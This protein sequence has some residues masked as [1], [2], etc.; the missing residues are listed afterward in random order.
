MLCRERLSL[1][2]VLYSASSADAP[3]LRRRA[4]VSWHLSYLHASWQMAKRQ[5]VSP[6]RGLPEIW[7]PRTS[8]W[9]TR[10]CCIPSWTLT[11]EKYGQLADD[12]VHQLVRHGDHLHHLLAL[13]MRLHPQTG[14]CLLGDCFHVFTTWH[15]QAVT[16]LAIDLNHHGD[17]V[18]Y[19][20]GLV[21]LGPGLRVDA[22]RM[23]AAV[24]QLFGDVGRDGG[25]DQQHLLDRPR[26]DIATLQRGSQ[27]D[28]QIRQLHQRA[29]GSVVLIAVQ[30]IAHAFDRLMHGAAQ[31]DLVRLGR[32][33]RG[34]LH[35]L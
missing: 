20:H 5:T 32:G 1:W 14:L 15:L 12:D 35:R 26:P 23:P 18:L 33:L 22:P 3:S 17:H 21:E 9:R 16:Q 6:L 24:P 8:T 27:P 2:T 34:R 31:I 4:W 7:V 25:H 11:L 10:I 13:D 19:G 28:H 30:V 29:D